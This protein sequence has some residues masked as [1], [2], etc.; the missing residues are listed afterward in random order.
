M[1]TI[2]S[3][4]PAHLTDDLRLICPVKGGGAYDPCSVW[5]YANFNTTTPLRVV[6]DVRSGSRRSGS[7]TFALEKNHIYKV[8]FP[9]GN[10]E[11]TSCYLSTFG[12]SSEIAPE[13]LIVEQR[14]IFPGGAAAY[15]EDE[16]Q[17]E[18]R[19][20]KY[21][22]EAQTAEQKKAARRAEIDT[23]LAA[24]AALVGS[25]K[26]VAWALELRRGLYVQFDLEF[27]WNSDD[28]P[29]SVKR[30]IK[31]GTTIEDLRIQIF[32]E[33]SAHNWIGNRNL[34]FHELVKKAVE[35]IEDR[36]K[37]V[38]ASPPEPV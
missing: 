1:T 2:L 36:A 20:L 24:F 30:L 27:V 32:S 18:L 14:S 10:R 26:Q 23:K 35:V 9:N 25:E 15:D 38:R 28:P 11:S 13:R 37:V 12:E 22:A 3:I 34:R 19:S 21:A 6:E 17:R 31:V 7:V 5:V 4:G 8:T 33:S 29:G 16:G